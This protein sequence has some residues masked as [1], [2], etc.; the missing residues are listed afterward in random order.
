MN[1]PVSHCYR[2]DT[3]NWK[4]WLNALRI[5][6][7]FQI[8]F[9]YAYYFLYLDPFLQHFE[10]EISENDVTKLSKSEWIKSDMK[11]W[12]I[13]FG[14]IMYLLFSF[15]RYV[16]DD[17]SRYL[18]AVLWSC[19]IY[20]INFLH[21][22]IVVIEEHLIAVWDT[23]MIFTISERVSFK[24]SLQTIFLILYICGEI[25]LNTISYCLEN[26]DIFSASMILSEM[27]MVWV[28]SCGHLF[29]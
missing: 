20:Y 23:S 9:L 22:G 6:Y 21:S 29:F 28:F 18:M 7:F 15:V 19:V 14:F 25:S 13:L 16:T 8:H 10:K 27:N 17:S 5:Y 24:Q 2:S 26:L 12:L 11:V 4:W 1:P 3:I